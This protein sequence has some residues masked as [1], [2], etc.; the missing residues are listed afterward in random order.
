L[1][2][3]FFTIET[4]PVASPGLPEGDGKVDKEN[5]KVP[6][7]NPTDTM[8]D[9]VAFLRFRLGTLQEDP[10][11]NDAKN[12]RSFYQG[13]KLGYDYEYNYFEGK[14]GGGVL[15]DYQLTPAWCEF[16]FE[17]V[18]TQLC[19]RKPDIWCHVPVGDAHVVDE[20]SMRLLTTVAVRYPQKDKD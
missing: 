1:D 11:R 4:P 2:K 20:P 13:R 12:R 3:H 15:F 16:V 18:F 6:S 8:E 17:L 9:Q 14:T 5:L 19:P 10:R 7:E